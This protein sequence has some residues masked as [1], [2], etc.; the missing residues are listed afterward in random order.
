[1]GIVIVYEVIYKENYNHFEEHSGGLFSTRQG[2]ENK[3]LTTTR[4]GGFIRNPH[5]IMAYKEYKYIHK[6]PITD[7]G[8]TN[9]AV[10]FIRE[11]DV[12]E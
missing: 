10:A 8:L 2:A 4:F 12:E 5:E 7:Y 1:M 11:R 6:N 9:E 3:I